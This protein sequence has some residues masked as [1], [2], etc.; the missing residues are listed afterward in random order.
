MITLQENL[1]PKRPWLP[2]MEFRD[3]GHTTMI[4]I[5]HWIFWNFF[6]RWEIQKAFQQAITCKIWTFIVGVMVISGILFIWGQSGQHKKLLQIFFKKIKENCTMF[7]RSIPTREALVH[8]IPIGEVKDMKSDVLRALKTSFSERK[9]W[10]LFLGSILTIFEK[11]KLHKLWISF[12]NISTVG[13]D[14]FEIHLKF[15]SNSIF[16]FITYPFLLIEF[17]EI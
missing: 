17:F 2:N 4:P 10:N 13:I 14:I 6:G 8:Y 7:D 16:H 3:F 11:E 1:T 12:F 9:L 5:C 15:V